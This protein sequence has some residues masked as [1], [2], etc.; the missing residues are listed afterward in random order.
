MNYMNSTRTTQAWLKA[1]ESFS[2]SPTHSWQFG[3]MVSKPD[4]WS[5]GPWIKPDKSIFYIAN[6][7][8]LSNW[9]KKT[10]FKFKTGKSRVSL[11]CFTWR[12]P[13]E[14]WSTEMKVPNL[15]KESTKSLK[16]EYQI[17]ERRVS[18]LWKKSTKSLKGDLYANEIWFLM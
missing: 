12:P 4:S 2:V 6:F 14:I 18:N 16:R 9:I 1:T 17:S 8:G 11:W 10:N 7:F 3:V 13:F 5:G 15:W